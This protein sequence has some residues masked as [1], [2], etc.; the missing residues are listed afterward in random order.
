[1]KKVIMYKDEECVVIKTIQLS[2]KRFTFFVGVNT[3]KILY[4]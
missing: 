1:M 3:K 4:S 2:E